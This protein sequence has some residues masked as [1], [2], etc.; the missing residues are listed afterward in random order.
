VR[1]PNIVGAHDIDQDGELHF[2]VME[3][4]EGNN[5]R[6]IINER[7]RMDPI[8]AAHYIRQA[9]LGLQHA[10]EAGLVHRDIK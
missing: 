9:A 5:L 1:H 3:Y 7:G 4:I 8:W 10:H 6:T 2:L